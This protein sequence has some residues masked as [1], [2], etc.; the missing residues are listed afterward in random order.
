MHARVCTWLTGVSKVLLALCT[1]LM[2]RTL[3]IKELVIRSVSRSERFVGPGNAACTLVQAINN[4][5]VGLLG[6]PSLYDP[7]PHALECHMTP[8]QQIFLEGFFGGALWPSCLCFDLA[9]VLLLWY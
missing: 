5:K 3:L 1:L 7:D 6:D 4:S 2:L 9:A 8:T